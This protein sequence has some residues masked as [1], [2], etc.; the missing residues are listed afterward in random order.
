[1]VRSRKRLHSEGRG[2]L[3]TRSTFVWEER[4]GPGYGG[5]HRSLQGAVWWKRL[6][7]SP[8]KTGNR[9]VMAPLV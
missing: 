1:M 4:R 6:D 5:P 3:V 2:G 7:S 8:R 9:Q